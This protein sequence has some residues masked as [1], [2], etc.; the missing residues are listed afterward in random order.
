VASAGGGVISRETIDPTE[1]PRR[2]K[3]AKHRLYEEKAVSELSAT[4]TLDAGS[5]QRPN[6]ERSRVVAR[7]C[8][9]ELG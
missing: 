8:P 2:T 5:G 1:Q 7:F 4:A 6:P 9:F 3:P